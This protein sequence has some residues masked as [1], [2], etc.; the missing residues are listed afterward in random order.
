MELS[1]MQLILQTWIDSDK[2]PSY[3]IM[4]TV[5]LPFVHH[6][7]ECAKQADHF[8]TSVDSNSFM[9]GRRPD[10]TKCWNFIN[11]FRN[12]PGANWTGLTL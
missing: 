11:D 9:S 2:V 6:L 3:L 4:H 10:T 5:K 1:V 12:G 7:G 8:L